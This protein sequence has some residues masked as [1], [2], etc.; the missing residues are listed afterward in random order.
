M[1]KNTK[2]DLAALMKEDVA[3]EV[4]D[5]SLNELFVVA[6]GK[7]PQTQPRPASGRYN[8]VYDVYT[9]YADTHYKPLSHF[10]IDG[11]NE[12]NSTKKDEQER[13]YKEIVARTTVFNG[14]TALFDFTNIKFLNNTANKSRFLKLLSTKLCDKD[15]DVKECVWDAN[16]DIAEGAISLS[17]ITDNPVILYAN[18]TDIIAILVADRRFENNL[19]MHSTK[20]VRISRVKSKQIVKKTYSSCARYLWVRH[21]LSSL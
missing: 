13:R 6:I 7:M 15:N 5:S 8:D 9:N 18:D 11:Y 21:K 3:V 1:R 16:Y 14:E 4:Y 17:E 10:L 19:I 2:S 12:P 20:R